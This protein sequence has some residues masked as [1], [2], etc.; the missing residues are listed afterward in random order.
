ML[1][2]ACVV[3]AAVFTPPPVCALLVLLPSL[4]R[5]FPL[6]A[7]QRIRVAMTHS[8]GICADAQIERM[9]PHLESRVMQYILEERAYAPDATNRMH[10]RSRPAAL[11]ARDLN[12]LKMIHDAMEFVMESTVSGVAKPK[13]A[14][15]A[16]MKLVV[17]RQTLLLPRTIYCEVYRIIKNATI[18]T[19]EGGDD[20]IYSRFRC[21]RYELQLLFDS[22]LAPPLLRISGNHA[23]PFPSEFGWLA[24]LRYNISDC[25]LM[26]LQRDFNMEYSRLGKIVKA[27][28]SWLFRQHSFRVTNAWHF[29]A[30]Q[31]EAFNTHLRDM[32]PPPPPGYEQLWAI[33]IDACLV[34]QFVSL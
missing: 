17:L 14:R 20:D 30:P 23:G 13:R 9:P 21:N 4:S 34:A 6:L 29:W 11:H 33:G 1:L 8:C 10:I 26:D 22:L 27:F 5:A 16:Y 15:K 25:N 18:A 28:E 7:A 32:D 3:P 12:V 2:L 19:F 24:W 31:V